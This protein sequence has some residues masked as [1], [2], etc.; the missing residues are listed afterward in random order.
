MQVFI[1]N[2]ITNATAVCHASGGAWC[3]ILF[4]LVPGRIARFVYINAFV[5]LPGSSIYT[6]DAQ[7]FAYNPAAV[8]A[9]RPAPPEGCRGTRVFVNQG[10]CRV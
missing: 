6:T 9:V 8:S 5:V 1:A 2:D 10:F 7:L 4:A 3:Q